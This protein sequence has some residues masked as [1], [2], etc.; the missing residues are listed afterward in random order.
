MK[1]VS[2]RDIGVG[3]GGGGVGRS[4]ILHFRGDAIF[5][6]PLKDLTLP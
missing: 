1:K 5:E 6:W 2:N 4:K 3:G